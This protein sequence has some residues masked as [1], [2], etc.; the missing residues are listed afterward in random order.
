MATTQAVLALCVQMSKLVD[1]KKATI[2]RIAMVKAYVTA[3]LR[4]VARW[5]REIYG[6]NGIIHEN[7]AMKAFMD[8]ES[9]Y[10][11]EGTYEVNTLVA[12]RDLTGVAAF[13]K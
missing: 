13:K 8:A 6:G 9:I 3:Q 11:Y 2:G 10:T 7:H 5:G 12:G 1:E 4:D